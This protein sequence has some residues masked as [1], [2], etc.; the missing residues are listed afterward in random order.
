[1]AEVRQGRWTA[2]IDG[3]FVV[4]IVGAR[5]NSKLQAVV[6]SQLRCKSWRTLVPCW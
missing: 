4:F 1:M 5:L 6:A 3:D 2:D